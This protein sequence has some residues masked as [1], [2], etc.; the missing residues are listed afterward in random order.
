MRSTSCGHPL[1]RRAGLTLSAGLDAQL[2]GGY[3]TLGAT[4]A[5]RVSW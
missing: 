1:Q 3:S 5:L 2:G 4:G